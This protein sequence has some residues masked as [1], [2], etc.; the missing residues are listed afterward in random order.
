MQYE[1][2]E[3]TDLSGRKTVFYSIKLKGED[4][5]LF[6]KFVLDNIIDFRK[7][8]EDILIRL[9]LMANQTGAR[10]HFFKLHEGKEGDPVCALYDDPD[11]KLRLY[12]IRYHDRTIILGDGGHK[13]K[14]TRAWQEKED[15]SEAANQ[16]ILLAADLDKKIRHGDIYWANQ[17]ARLEG[18]T[19]NLD[20]ED[21]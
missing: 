19:N 4:I 2:V 12:C 5:T 3:L 9:G 18:N 10:K 1:L 11:K 15:L 13:P 21:E 8:V 6:E 14:G 7:E 17:D 20:D 16:M